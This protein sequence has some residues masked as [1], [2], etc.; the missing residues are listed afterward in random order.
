MKGFLV[1]ILLSFLATSLAMKR[2]LD[3]G[4]DEMDQ[5]SS[6]PKRV[7]RVVIQER[8]EI[9]PSLPKIEDVSKDFCLEEPENFLD[10]TLDHFQAKAGDGAEIF[11]S[12]YEGDLEKLSVLLGLG[13]NFTELLYTSD[14]GKF[15]NLLEF[16]VAFG[17]PDVCFFLLCGEFAE[18]VEAMKSSATGLAYLT[19][20]ESIRAL[21]DVRLPM[22][23]KYGHP[24][25]NFGV[26]HEISRIREFLKTVNWSIDAQD[27]DGKTALMFAFESNCSAT[28][29]KYLLEIGFTADGQDKHGQTVFHKLIFWHCKLTSQKDI[30]LS[31]Y[32]E[33][34][35]I[36][37]I[38][39]HPHL[40]DVPDHLGNTPLHYALKDRRFSGLCSTF[41]KAGATGEHT[42]LEGKWAIQLA[43]S[44]SSGSKARGEMEMLRSVKQMIMAFAGLF[45]EGSIFSNIPVEI[46]L[47]HIF[48]VFVQLRHDSRPASSKDAYVLLRCREFPQPIAKHIMQFIS[49]KTARKELNKFLNV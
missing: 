11:M 9:I 17:S 24:G 28:F 30:K 29:L 32:D 14:K 44:L 27:Q 12:A 5:F 8:V 15:W 22:P 20:N 16:A 25:F 2:F 26:E 23:K 36:P 19:T 35:V 10:L 1:G 13:Q 43:H 46:V 21:F 31:S 47:Q 34:L 33:M 39:M 7:R 48:P 18:Q 37:L 49:S 45:D 38:K 4:K 41:I 40:I 3:I 42:N 6:S